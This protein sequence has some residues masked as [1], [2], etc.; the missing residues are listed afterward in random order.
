MEYVE[1]IRFFDHT[2]QPAIK[3]E[4]VPM[5]AFPSWP[6]L[7]AEVRRI[8][9]R[10]SF[11][12]PRRV[13]LRFKGDRCI[14]QEAQSRT[15]WFSTTRIPPALGVC[16]ESRSEALKC[17]ELAFGTIIHPD[18]VWFDFSKDILVF[19]RP[20]VPTYNA[21]LLPR[22][23]E[24]RESRVTGGEEKRVHRL[25][26]EATPDLT[27][28]VN[29]FWKEIKLMPGLKTLELHL[30][31]YDG[32]VDLACRIVLQRL[33]NFYF[34]NCQTIKEELRPWTLPR[35]TIH[36][37]DPVP[38]VIKSIRPTSATVDFCDILEWRA[39]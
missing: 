29:M 1:K 34:R 2:Y 23:F 15:G 30:A 39:Y 33:R 31:G 5:D 6:Y 26:I 32:N 28:K 4:D 36:M 18:S 12:K 24:T 38:A 8:I 20:V 3:K 21:Y 22:L 13:I 7:P 37:S 19:K 9:W 17:Y 14:G 25:V 10:F 16:R 27:K 35:L 11:A